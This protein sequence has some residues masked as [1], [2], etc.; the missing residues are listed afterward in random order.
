MPALLTIASSRPTSLRHRAT[1]SSLVTSSACAWMPSNLLNADMSVATTECPRLASAC[2][3]AIPMPPAAPVIKILRAFDIRGVL[4]TLAYAGRKKAEC[5]RNFPVSAGPC[6]DCHVSQS[7]DRGGAK[8]TARAT[9]LSGFGLILVL[10]CPV[11]NTRV[12]FPS[13]APSRKSLLNTLISAFFSPCQWQS[14]PFSKTYFGELQR[15]S[16]KYYW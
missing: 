4:F 13:P 16:L 15:T 9:E 2:A 3:V 1:E 6:I 12:R 5:A 10:I 11:I 14:K 8:T 7:R